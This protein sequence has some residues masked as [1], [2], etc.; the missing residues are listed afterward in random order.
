MIDFEHTR[1]ID[2]PVFF[3]ARCDVIEARVALLD[4]LTTGSVQ[5]AEDMMSHLAVGNCFANADDPAC[6]PFH[7]GSRMPCGGPCVTKTST[8]AGMSS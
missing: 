1:L 4:Q 8:E 2:K 3:V 6:V 5:V 7:P